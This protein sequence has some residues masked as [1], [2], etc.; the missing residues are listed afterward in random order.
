[1]ESK[2]LKRLRISFAREST[3]HEKEMNKYLEGDQGY[4]FHKGMKRA[5][6]YA[7]LKV[8]EEINRE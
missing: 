3:Y 7:H 2:A 1:M 5:Y 4:D 8:I 6:H